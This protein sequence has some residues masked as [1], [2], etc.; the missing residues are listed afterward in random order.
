[1]SLIR[2]GAKLTSDPTHYSLYVI[3]YIQLLQLR[4][5]SEV[6]GPVRKYTELPV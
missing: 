3:L 1:M 4:N 5:G 6:N 2:I